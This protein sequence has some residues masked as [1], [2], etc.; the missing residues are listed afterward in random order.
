MTT[1]T[2]R[3]F[4]LIIPKKGS[5]KSLIKLIRTYTIHQVNLVSLNGKTHISL[6]VR[7]NLS[8]IIPSVFNIPIQA[9]VYALSILLRI[10]RLQI[11]IEYDGDTRL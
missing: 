8:N 10:A 1:Y 4:Q 5:D 7:I 3:K 9:S 6:P 2:S 11:V